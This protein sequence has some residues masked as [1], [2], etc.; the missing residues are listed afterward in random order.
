MLTEKILKPIFARRPFLVSANP[1]MLETLKG[2]GFKTFD[3]WFDESYDD[4]DKGLLESI[5][6]LKSNVEFIN[7]KS[8][9]ELLGLYEEMKPTLEHNYRR[10]LQFVWKQKPKHIE[11]II[12]YIE[13][14]K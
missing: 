10:A 6:I 12:K 4:K 3:K 8:R 2:Y 7:G 9:R 1:G 13:L 5:Q 14:N 11:E